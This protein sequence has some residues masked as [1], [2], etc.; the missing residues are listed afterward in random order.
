[1][2]PMKYESVDDLDLVT[3]LLNDQSWSM[4]QKMDGTRGWALLRPL[5]PAV[6][7]VGLDDHGEPLP[8]K[9]TAATQHLSGIWN[10][11][12][13]IHSMLGLG[14]AII[15]D[16]EVMIDSGEFRVFDLPLFTDS[17]SLQVNPHD[18]Q[19]R[20]REVLNHLA[21]FF[22]DPV[23]LVPEA[24]TAADK[25]TLLHDCRRRGVEGVVFKYRRGSYVTTGKRTDHVLKH[26]FV[27]TADV[28]VLAEHR[29]R[30]AA[31]REVGSI[32]FGVAAPFEATMTAA[33]QA[34]VQLVGDTPV[35]PMGSCSVIGK[36]HVEPGDV[37]EVTYLY[38]PPTG[39]LI[40]PRMT[41]LRRDKPPGECGIDQFAE[42]SREVVK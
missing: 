35:L 9:H 12:R 18:L 11:L 40:Q 42:Y 20:R 1:M 23:S 19:S 2:R 25:Q 7:A 24:V 15:L 27:K 38:R 10:G 21:Q 32:E 6:M 3:D 16:G 8:L 30:N 17:T 26:K 41:R 13:H 14:S 37:I 29:S 31:G 28:V 4:E 5:Q 34:S 22:I 39:G 33:Q 36:P